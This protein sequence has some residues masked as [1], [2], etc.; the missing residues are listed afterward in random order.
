MTFTLIKPN[1]MSLYFVV[2]SLGGKQVKDRRMLRDKQKTEMRQVHNVIL[3]LLRTQ[4][5]DNIFSI[6]RQ[7]IFCMQKII[8]PHPLRNKG[9]SLKICFFFS[10][11]ILPPPFFPLGDYQIII[12]L[13]EIPKRELVVRLI[14]EKFNNLRL[15]YIKEI[16]STCNQ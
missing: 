5:Y 9:N 15:M 10:E 11:I 1:L 4:K 13:K 8:K 16:D 12:G 14:R 3:W 7:N 2:Q 6:S